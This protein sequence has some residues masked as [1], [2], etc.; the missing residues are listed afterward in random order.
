MKARRLLLDDIAKV[1]TAGAGLVR[2][3]TQEAEHV[4][5][6]R[7][8]RLIDRMNLVPRDEFNVVKELAVKAGIVNAALEQRV[9]ALEASIQEKKKRVSVTQKKDKVTERKRN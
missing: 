4:L 9:V 2:G 6:R 5:H 1:A 7:L 8:E 3:A